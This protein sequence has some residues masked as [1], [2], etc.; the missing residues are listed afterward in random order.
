MTPKVT[1]DA[2]FPL[3]DLEPAWPSNRDKRMLA[4]EV[5]MLAPEVSPD[6]ICPKLPQRSLLLMIR[7]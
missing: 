3:T 6:L 1:I 4:P 2:I 5:Y 7:N